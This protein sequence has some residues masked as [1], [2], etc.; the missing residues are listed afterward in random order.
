M[1]K[2]SCILFFSYERIPEKD[3][4]MDRRVDSTCLRR[5]PPWPFTPRN[6]LVRKNC[7]TT[8]TPPP[9]PT[10]PHPW[11]WQTPGKRRNA[12]RAEHPGAPLSGQIRS[13]SFPLG[14][15]ARW[16]AGP[17]APRAVINSWIKT[18]QAFQSRM[19]TGNKSRKSCFLLQ[20]MNPTPTGRNYSGS[21]RS[22]TSPG[23][24]VDS[25]HVTLPGP[26]MFY[27]YR[28]SKVGF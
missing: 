20:E 27:W 5:A 18:R 19:R 13:S 17:S 10:A 21:L 7:I 8:T 24:Y 3:K 25:V 26:A 23:L 28:I 4:R 16:Q 1:P 12:V 22:K 11:R 6:E 9:S 15:T 14:V 2:K